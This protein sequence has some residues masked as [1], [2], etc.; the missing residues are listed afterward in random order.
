MLREYGSL[1][2]PAMTWR[3]QTLRS[4]HILY[5]F[6]SAFARVLAES[7]IYKVRMGKDK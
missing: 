7:V 1:G 5:W 4:S 6:T 3:E 2:E